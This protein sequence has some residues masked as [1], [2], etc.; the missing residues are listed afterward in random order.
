MQDYLGSPLPRRHVHAEVG[1]GNHHEKG[2][3]PFD[4]RAVEIG[5]AGVIR[6][7]AARR[8]RRA[9]MVQSHE[10]RHAAG[11]AGQR[12]RRRKYDVHAEQGLGHFLY[13]RHVPIRRRPR[14]FSVEHMD[15]PPPQLRK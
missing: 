5:H 6:R 13:A 10:E 15:R 7:K 12:S 11:H 14:A 8:N 4:Q 1:T 3:H 9:G 2:Q